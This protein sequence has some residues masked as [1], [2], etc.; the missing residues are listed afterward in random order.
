MKNYVFAALYSLASALVGMVLPFTEGKGLM[1]HPTNLFWGFIYGLGWY[2]A[3]FIQNVRS[4]NVQL[5]GS[6]IWPFI[7]LVGVGYSF[8]RLLSD[9]ASQKVRII[10]VALV[11]TAVVVPEHLVRSTSL[12]FIPTYSG[13]L[14]V[15]Y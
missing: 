11:L 8:G 3:G 9:F 2:V 14:S 4:P 15:V 5:F 1:Q 13:T 7:V 6:L 12:R 10:A